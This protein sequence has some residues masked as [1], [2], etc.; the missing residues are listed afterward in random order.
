MPPTSHVCGLIA[1][2]RVCLDVHKGKEEPRCA[3][4]ILEPAVFRT[5]RSVFQQI[6]YATCFR[7]QGIVQ[8]AEQAVLAKTDSF[9]SLWDTQFTSALQWQ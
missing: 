3:E 4:Y 6:F 1:N 7:A 9:F 5:L 8:Q 2:T